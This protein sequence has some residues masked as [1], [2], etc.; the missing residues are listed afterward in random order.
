MSQC[1]GIN[2][3]KGNR[4]ASK[5]C[6]P[7][8]TCS[9]HEPA[10]PTEEEYAAALAALPAAPPDRSTLP[11][12]NNL[13]TLSEA[14]LEKRLLHV[15]AAIIPCPDYEKHI[16]LLVISNRLNIVNAFVMRMQG[17]RR[18]NDTAEHVRC[19]LAEC[20]ADKRRWRE[21]METPLADT[22]EGL[23]AQKAACN[24]LFMDVEDADM[25]CDYQVWQILA[26]DEIK[27]RKEAIGAK[28]ATL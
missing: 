6:T 9:R 15:K 25:G 28:W 2:K 10:R 12:T 17:I 18:F 3:V 23:H 22:K 27:Q 21:T 4:C 5:A 14:E 16:Q 8:G 7:W 19:V 24:R 1:T 20:L 11:S 26:F 13:H